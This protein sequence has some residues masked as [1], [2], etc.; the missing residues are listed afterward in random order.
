MAIS[1]PHLLRIKILAC[2][3]CFCFMLACNNA[4]ENSTAPLEKTA[5]EQLPVAKD[6]QQKQE[7]QTDKPK[8]SSDEPKQYNNARFKEVTVQKIS[9]G[10]YKV[11]GKAQVFE[12]SFA[13]VVEDGHN[14]LKKGH[15][16]TDAGAPEWGNFQ[17]TV[18]AIKQRANSTLTLILFEVSAKD[19]SRQYE[20]PIT[21]EK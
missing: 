8:P 19:G 14:E 20:L 4:R 7:A 6:S 12:A 18:E 17:F 16:M 10:K 15:E 1:Y 3:I 2:S 13:W 9:E 21:L 5:E 11:Q